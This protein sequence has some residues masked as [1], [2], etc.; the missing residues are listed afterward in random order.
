MIA[1]AERP[2]ATFARD[3]LPHFGSVA[4][5]RADPIVLILLNRFRRQS[6]LPPG[7]VFDDGATWRGITYDGKIV[8]VYG[9]KWTGRSV[10]ITNIC[11][12][13]SRYGALAVYALLAFYRQGYA[14]GA[15]T[16]FVAPVLV[17]N[18]RMIRALTRVFGD[19]ASVDARGQ[20]I[21]HAHVYTLGEVGSYG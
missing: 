9:E 16:G 11:P 14:T 20:L 2:L 5:E 13:A 8:L 19:I 7:P 1:V 12:A 6:G 17:R 4:V 15:I 3:M 10:L 21:P 18:T